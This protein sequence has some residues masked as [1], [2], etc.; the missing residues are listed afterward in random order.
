MGMK[1]WKIHPALFGASAGSIDLS[2]YEP[3][4]E[5]MPAVFGVTASPDL[6]HDLH[7]EMGY[8][9]MVAVVRAKKALPAYV[10]HSGLAYIDGEVMLATGPWAQDKVSQ[11]YKACV[12][13]VPEL[14]WGI[15]F[16]PLTN[17]FI[18]STGSSLTTLFA[19]NDAIDYITRAVKVKMPD[20]YTVT[21]TESDA[22]LAAKFNIEEC[23]RCVRDH[24]SKRIVPFISA[25]RNTGGGPVALTADLF[26]ATINRL[27]ALGI[28][29]FVL[30]GQIDDAG[31][32]AAYQAILDAWSPD[33]LAE[34]EDDD[35]TPVV[36]G[37]VS[38]PIAPAG[39]G[40]DVWTAAG[41]VAASGFDVADG[42]KGDVTVSGSGSVWTVDPPISS[43]SRVFA[44][45][46][47]T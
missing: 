42:D 11:A 14:D 12:A 44:Y 43:A 31:E 47:F 22:E 41:W 10:N 5:I 2:A 3:A 45:E 18:T 16:D 46:R 17:Y 9:E 38:V 28:R 30:W 1:K 34:Y 15:Y 36:R 4:A 7:E 21:T 39:A 26:M 37:G 20:S 23:F 40:T 13:G 25:Y 6:Q 8:D 19:A 27:Y 29:E 33:F 32:A 24:A 35:F